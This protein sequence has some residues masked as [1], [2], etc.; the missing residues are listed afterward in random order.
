MSLKSVLKGLSRAAPI[1]IANAPA[2]I[3]AAKEVK[4]AL[5]K[6]ARKP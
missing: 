3:A 5:K 4:R 1:I 6:P 2:V